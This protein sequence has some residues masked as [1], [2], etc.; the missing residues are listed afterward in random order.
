MNQFLRSKNLNKNHPGLKSHKKQQNHT[1]TN[2]GVKRPILK[3]IEIRYEGMDKR[4]CVTFL[5]IGLFCE[6]FVNLV[7][8]G[9]TLNR[10]QNSNFKRQYF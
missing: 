8:E 2:H 7:F 6:E 1:L 10:F 3:L 9:T 5:K 4:F